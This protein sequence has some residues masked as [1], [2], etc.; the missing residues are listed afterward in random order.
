MQL[1]GLNFIDWN[2]IKMI[3]QTKTA[4]GSRSLRVRSPFIVVNYRAVIS[5]PEGAMRNKAEQI[6]GKDA[7]YFA[8][9]KGKRMQIAGPEWDDKQVELIKLYNSLFSLR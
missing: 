2:A 6:L 5:P 9:L 7:D 4:T 3:G 8:D 1:G